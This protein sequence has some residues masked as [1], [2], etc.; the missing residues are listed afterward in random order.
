[1]IRVSSVYNSTSSEDESITGRWTDVSQSPHLAIR[2]ED[3]VFQK[4][5]DKRNQAKELEITGILRTTRTLDIS[6]VT[7]LG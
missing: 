3:R 6:D 2:A 1:M 4:L 5:V 7:V